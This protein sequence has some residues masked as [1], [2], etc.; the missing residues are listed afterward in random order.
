MSKDC[1]QLFK[2]VQVLDFCSKKLQVTYKTIIE[3]VKVGKNKNLKWCPKPDCGSVVRKPG[4]CRN[5]ATC[6]CGQQMCF[7]CGGE[8]HR[9][10]C[11]YEGGLAFKAW[12]AVHTVTRCPKCR[13]PT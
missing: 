13:I 1:K 5:Q 6:Q 12:Q 7:K 3:D 8:W 10:R 4:W 9:G 2:E 11:Q